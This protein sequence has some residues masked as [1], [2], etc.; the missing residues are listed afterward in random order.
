MKN[1]PLLKIVCLLSLIL[2]VQITALTP[3]CAGET[4]CAALQARIKGLELRVKELESMLAG[5]ERGAG[6]DATS[7]AP[8]WQ[9]RKNWKRLS[10]GMREAE[11]REVLGE[12]SKVIQGVKTLWYYPNFYRG[13]LT[14]DEN[15]RLSG[16][17]EP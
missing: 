5:T 3:S 2:P 15:G 16:W 8:G 9:N 7:R 12:P 6:T 10:L 14:F 13:H 1:G 11:V 4:D 17:N